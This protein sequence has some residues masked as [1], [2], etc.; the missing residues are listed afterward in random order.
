MLP[1]RTLAF[2]R[3][4]SVP[5]D[6]LSHQPREPVDPMQQGSTNPARLLAPRGGNSGSAMMFTP[7]GERKQAFRL[8]ALS[9]PTPFAAAA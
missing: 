1:P 9:Q 4:E 7:L 6:E 3:V 2:D 5:D 8:C